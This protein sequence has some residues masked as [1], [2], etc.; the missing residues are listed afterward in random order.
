MMAGP[1]FFPIRPPLAAT[2]TAGQGRSKRPR[3]P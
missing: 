1:F 2:A 3:R